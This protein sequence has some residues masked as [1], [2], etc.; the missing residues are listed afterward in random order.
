MSE[1]GVKV[2]FLYLHVYLETVLSKNQVKSCFASLVC[3][4]GDAAG[5]G[6]PLRS[7]SGV[8]FSMAIFSHRVSLGA[9]A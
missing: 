5:S 6:D 1:L 7:L 3:V 8:S 9:R 2:A 4:W